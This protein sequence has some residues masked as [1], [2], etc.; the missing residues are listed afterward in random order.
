MA[1]QTTPSGLSITGE[2]IGVSL[3]AF[4]R[5]LAAKEV[6]RGLRFNAD[7]ILREGRLA[8]LRIR[9]E[10]VRVGSAQQAGFAKAGVVIS[11][12]P[13]EVMAATADAV[14]RNA[15]EARTSSIRRA[16]EL[17]RAAAAR[18]KSGGFGLFSL[19]GTIVG[20]VYGGAGGAALGSEIGGALDG[21]G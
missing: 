5:H 2:I 11:G 19:V 15:L 20:G 14:E 6:E 8:E 1:E 12:T 3:Q 7:E 10:G 13:L 9:E 4:G 17:R 21:A 18:R 16:G